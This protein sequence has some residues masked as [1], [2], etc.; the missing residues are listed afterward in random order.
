VNV[1]PGEDLA[2]LAFRVN[3]SFGLLAALNGL[4]G[5]SY[6]IQPGQTLFIEAPRQQTVVVQPGEALIDIAL[7]TNV[8]FDLLASLNGLTAPNY[9]ILP[10]QVLF[11][12]APPP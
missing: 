12:E 8:G 10:G 7:R 4:I 11:I 9:T 5:P 6:T 1:L 3:V 2:D